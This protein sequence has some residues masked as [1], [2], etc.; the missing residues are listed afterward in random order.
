MLIKPDCYSIQ[1]T[2]VRNYH[3][4]LCSKHS[5]SPVS[6]RTVNPFLTHIPLCILFIVAQH[7]T[8][9]FQLDEETVKA[10]IKK[11][12]PGSLTQRQILENEKSLCR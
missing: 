9:S 12:T 8:N 1:A 6:T 11:S 7:N 2:A 3:L 10:T 4:G 5:D